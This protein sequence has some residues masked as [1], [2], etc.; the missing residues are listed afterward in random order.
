MTYRFTGRCYAPIFIRSP[1]FRQPALQGRAG[2]LFVFAS[3]A[4]GLLLFVSAAVTE[5][6]TCRKW[7]PMGMIPRA[8]S[9]PVG[10]IILLSCVA[11]AR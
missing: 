2:A 1:P 4:P 11:S 8:G 7:I 6:Q 5:W 9:N 10:R 3:G